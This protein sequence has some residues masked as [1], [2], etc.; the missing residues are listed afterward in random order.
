MYLPSFEFLSFEI[1]G[2]I[3]ILTWL[4]LLT[5]IPQNVCKL[6]AGLAFLVQ[7]QV[8]VL[9][10]D[11][12]KG[13]F[14]T[15]NNC[16]FLP[17]KTLHTVSFRGFV[18][19]HNGESKPDRCTAQELSQTC[20]LLLMQ[21]RTDFGRMWQCS[22]TSRKMNTPWPAHSWTGEQISEAAHYNDETT[23]WCQFYP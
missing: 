10:G 2:E 3:Q 7:Q 8:R 21:L 15:E 19:R 23:V 9:Q 14:K 12:Y 20:K 18:K 6:E 5:K 16:K 4:K 1:T 22:S 17:K 11:V 13:H